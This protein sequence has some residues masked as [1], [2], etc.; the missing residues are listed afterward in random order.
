[1]WRSHMVIGASSWL[2]LQAL[3]GPLTG[4][5]LDWRERA[6]GAVIAAGGALVCDMD[7]P[8]SR[9]ANALGPLTRLA[10]R[11]IG[12]AS[13]GHRQG[14]HSLMFCSAT[15]LLAAVLIAQQHVV[16]LGAGVALTVGELG[17][18]AIAYAATALTVALLLPVRGARAGVITLAIVAGAAS[19]HPAAVIVAAG[20]TIGCFSHLLADYLTPEGIAPLWPFSRRRIHLKVIHRTGDWRETTVVILTA[21]VTVAIAWSAG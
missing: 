2:G 12:H 6:C 11:G 5:G 16:Q 10:A 8:D 14:T 20:L 18:L 1:M 3:A 13:G 9:L 21:L 17:A 7:T 19:T 4:S 15:G